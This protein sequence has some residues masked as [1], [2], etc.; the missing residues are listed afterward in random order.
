LPDGYKVWPDWLRRI[1]TLLDDEA[2]IDVVALALEPRWPQS[3]FIKNLP[4]LTIME[5]TVTEFR[6]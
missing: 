1:D 4:A 2:V 3:R 5:R 6:Q